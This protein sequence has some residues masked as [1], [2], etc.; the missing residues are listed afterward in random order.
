MDLKKHQDNCIIIVVLKL[1]NYEVHTR[2]IVFFEMLPSAV[3]FKKSVPVPENLSKTQQLIVVV[4]N[5]NKD[6][7]FE[8]W[9]L[10]M[11]FHCFHHVHNGFW[12][13]FY[14]GF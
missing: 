11:T 6:N 13:L 12:A 9:E 2:T 5:Q 3:I 8:C 14:K 4:H 10:C 1:K 7:V